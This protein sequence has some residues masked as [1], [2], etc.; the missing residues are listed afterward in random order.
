MHVTS[1]TSAYYA[2]FMLLFDAA[3][4]EVRLADLGEWRVSNNEALAYTP[5]AA[6]NEYFRLELD[7]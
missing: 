7:V 2:V 6:S 5:I 4:L 1:E 3:F